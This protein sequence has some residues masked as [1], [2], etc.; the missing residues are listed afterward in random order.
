MS[1]LEKLKFHAWDSVGVVVSHLQKWRPRGCSTEKDFEKSLFKY[2][3]EKLP[4]IQVTKQ[5]AQGRIRADLMVG[6]KV[7]IELK[8]N[9]NSTAKYQRLIGQ[10][11]EYRDWDGRVV[12][13]LTGETDPNLRKEL[14][15]FLRREG[16]T[17]EDWDAK[18]AVFEK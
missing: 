8:H 18:V 12:I 4:E 6:G 1:F 14:R 7:I 15:S 5:Y 13:L 11:T 3:H 9:L 17:E 16:L 2:L 10:L